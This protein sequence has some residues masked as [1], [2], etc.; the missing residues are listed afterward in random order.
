MS[1]KSLSLTGVWPLAG[2]FSAIDQTEK[3]ILPPKDLLLEVYSFPNSM[4]D[5]PLNMDQLSC[6]W[7]QARE[8]D[9]HAFGCIHRELFNGLY[10]YSLKLLQDSDL[11]NDGSSQTDTQSVTIPVSLR[12]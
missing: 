5:T 4:D 9:D 8:G 11:A 12:P 6:W 1:C 10:N 2:K 7:Q 3:L